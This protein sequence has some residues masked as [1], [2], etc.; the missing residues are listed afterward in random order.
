MNREESDGK[1]KRSGQINCEK[2]TFSECVRL[3]GYG[4]QQMQAPFVEMLMND[5]RHIV[6][7]VLENGGGLQEEINAGNPIFLAAENGDFEL[8]QLLMERGAESSTKRD[9]A[10]ERAAKNGHLSIVQLLFNR[11]FYPQFVVDD[12]R[13]AN[14]VVLA[15]QYGHLDIVQF[16]DVVKHNVIIKANILNT[17]MIESVR[18]GQLPVV[19]YLLPM[20]I[21]HTREECAGRPIYEPVDRLVFSNAAANGRIDILE[22]FQPFIDAKAFDVNVTSALCAALENDQPASTKFIMDIYDVDMNKLLRFAVQFGYTKAVEFAFQNGANLSSTDAN[23]MLWIAAER[24]FVIIARQ[25]VTHGARLQRK[26]PLHMN[27]QAEDKAIQ[28]L[29][30]PLNIQ[31][32]NIPIVPRETIAKFTTTSTYGLY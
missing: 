30:Q 24:G 13:V 5:Q 15:A 1:R 19:K 29:L 31:N 10:L 27:R 22:W 17:M 6:K 7:L 8:V 28:T 18:N 14:A 23:D 2:R 25:L 12:A 3:L 11:E 16:L 32:P 20:F 4:E 9:S 21:K 26:P